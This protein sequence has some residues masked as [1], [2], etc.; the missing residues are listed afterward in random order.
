MGGHIIELIPNLHR[1]LKH[2][3]NE[4]FL[5]ISLGNAL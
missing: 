2:I 5:S 3:L 1:F 4:G